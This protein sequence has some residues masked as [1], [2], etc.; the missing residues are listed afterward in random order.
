[1]FASCR[2]IST[3]VL[4]ALSLSLLPCAA[5]AQNATNY[6]ILSNG[7]DVMYL[8]V[9]AGGNQTKADGLG[10]WIAG[11]DLKGSHVLGSTGDFGYL[12]R[13]VRES[14]CVMHDPVGG[15]Q[16][17]IQFRGLMF[18]EL[19]GLNAHAQP[20]FLNPACP[21]SGPS[22]PLGNSAGFIPYGVGPGSSFSF[23]LLSLPPG[24]GPAPS[25][26]ILVPNHGL[27]PSSASGTITPV[28]TASNV[29][30]PIPSA[31]F[32]W[33]VQFSFVPSGIGLL[34]DIDGLWH[35]LI[36]SDDNNQYWGFSDDELNIWQSNTVASD[37][38]VTGL[39]LFSANADYDM[40]LTC[41]Q[42]STMATLAPVGLHQAG[43]YYTQTVNVQNEYG[44]VVNPNGGFDVGR[45]S[46]AISLSGTAGVPNPV[47]GLG[48]QNPGAT[49]KEPTLGFLSWD[50]GGDENGSVRFAWV[51]MDLLGASGGDP[52]S[53]PGVTQLGGTIRV[54][55]VSAGYPQALT[56][57]CSLI[58]GH[59]TQPGFG[60][61]GG[62]PAGAF[63][64]GSIAGASWQVP[65]GAFP[66]GCLGVPV[67]LTY[68]TSGQT[69]VL[70]A[71]GTLTFDP[72]IADTSGSRELYLFN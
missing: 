7:F 70:G 17:E 27:V 60:D 36:N 59:V 8:G 25:S 34:D 3:A 18:M 20:I 44:V 12:M 68:G 46:S 65:V 15:G 45:G 55:V 51:S 24:V 13:G 71:P 10:T 11:E 66:A 37:S 21:A 35:Y 32:C 19:D 72:S 40:L 64:V 23:A 29:S 38:S 31:G 69:G 49:G 4:G 33:S 63:G 39:L 53:D 67:N 58:F 42:T 57:R 30:L 47:T 5:V 54:P 56:R 43:A 41:G 26:L 9:G 2:L 28:I 14:A 50:N 16:L 1:M 48:N 6:H 61:P 22:F 62:F 52:A